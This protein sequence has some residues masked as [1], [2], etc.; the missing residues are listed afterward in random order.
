MSSSTVSS[1]K[2]RP[3]LPCRRHRL[4]ARL[5]EDDSTNVHHCT[6]RLDSA[7]LR[8][9]AGSRK[10]VSIF[11]AEPAQHD[12]AQNGHFQPKMPQ[13]QN[14][15]AGAD[16]AADRNM[17][18]AA[19]LPAKTISTNGDFVSVSRD[20]KRVTSF[21]RVRLFMFFYLRNFNA[22]EF[23]VRQGFFGIYSNA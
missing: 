14:A 16:R 23:F 12:C 7:L 2:S 11:S 15:D 8:E 1:I 17:P 3:G 4:C 19:R 22:L 20:V 18:A 5:C 13:P 9:K 6:G 10:T 21:A